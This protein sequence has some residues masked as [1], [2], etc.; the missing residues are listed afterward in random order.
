MDR[1]R[2][3]VTFFWAIILFALCANYGEARGES[4]TPP[5]TCYKDEELIA[6]AL[7]NFLLAQSF[8]AVKCGVVDSDLKYEKLSREVVDKHTPTIRK[9]IQPLWEY[10]KRNGIDPSK[11]MVESGVA[12]DA[13]INQSRPTQAECVQFYDQ[14]LIRREDWG[15][16]ISSVMA[17]LMISE[18]T[19]KYLC[20]K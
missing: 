4:I 16:I 1:L 14:M 3:L 5:T 9:F 11:Y 19:Q 18:D 7:N 2:E 17:E 12:V 8:K 10:T 15:R 13:L 20:K 6:N